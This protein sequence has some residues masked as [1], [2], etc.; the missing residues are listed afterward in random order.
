M[1][2]FLL[3]LVSLIFSVQLIGQETIQVF[4]R[5]TEIPVSFVKISDG[6]GEVY[7]ADI[8]GKLELK[9]H[10]SRTYTFR[11]FQYKDT[12]IRGSSLLRHQLVFMTPDAQVLTE[13]IVTPGENPAHRIIR[14]V[15]QNQRENDPLK[16]NSFHYDSYSKFYASAQLLDGVDRDTITDTTTIKT[17][18]MLERQY[19]FLIETKANRTF[20]P[21]NYDKEEV[22][23]YNVSGV[24]EPYFA[25]LINQ[26]QSFSFYENNFKLGGTD[27]INPIA[28]GSIRRYLFILEDT[29]VN[30][31]TNDT[32]FTI[33]FRPRLS[34]SFDGLE[35][36]LY[37]NT[38]GWAIERVIASPYNRFDKPEL[39]KVKIIQ[40][41]AFTNSK[42][43]FPRK[44]STEL[45]FPIQFGDFGR[46]IGRSSLYI[47]KVEFD[48]DAKKGFNP[49]SVVVGENALTDSLALKE[50]RADHYSGKEA[51]TYNYLDSLAED[52]NLNRY[53]ELVKIA[54]TG[55]IPIKMF[56]IP[57]DK[58]TSYNAQEGVR[59]GLGL[60]TNRKFSKVAKLGGYFAY[61]FKDKEWKW[62]GDLTFTL[63]QKSLMELKLYYSDDLHPRGGNNFYN[64]NFSLSDPTRLSNLFINLLDRERYAGINVGGLITPNIKLQLFGNYKRFT[65]IDDYEFAPPS[66]D[67]SAIGGFDVAEVGMIFTW[68]IRE[69]VM[70]LEDNRFSLGSNWPKVTFKAARGLDGLFDSNYDYYRFNLKIDQTFKIRGVGSIELIGMAGMTVGD[71]PLT[72]SQIQDGT[73]LNFGIY[74]SNRF[75]TMLPAEFFSDKNASLFVNFILPPI[76]NR[77][78]WTEPLFILYSGFGIGTMQHKAMHRNF[79]FDTPKNGYYESG[80]KID[81]LLKASIMGVGLGVFYR[82]GPYH[83]PKEIDNFIAKITVRFNI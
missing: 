9:I 24:K 81:N 31:S 11:F 75:Q 48:I 34:K 57:V 13:I 3:I 21:P 4:D 72:L 1:R 54:S 43:W 63:H 10:P 25:T 12:T 82:Y 44:I 78:K 73:G 30:A 58:I 22:T 38:N 52:E 61:G 6:E 17:L 64:D 14:N 16:N 80:L 70:M 51:A 77:T 35:G 79:E 42:K 19:I 32:T 20:N 60:E 83:L 18:E 74:V 39:F 33:S 65:F 69:R 23:A 55:V 68:S 53:F 59:L 29:L 7:I 50:A 26:F 71:V 40:E 28:P 15:M 5:Q 67:K 37:I 56:G 66:P 47:N 46:G 2:R 8:D 62:G 27:Y 36:Y 49:I 45:D 41:Y 76:K